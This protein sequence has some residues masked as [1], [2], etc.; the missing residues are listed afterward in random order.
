MY[1][2]IRFLSSPEHHPELIRVGQSLNLGEQE[3]FRGIRRAGDGF[4]CD[5]SSTPTWPEHRSAIMAFVTLH[6]RQ[7]AA[8]LELGGQV[9]VDVAIEPEDCDR[10]VASLRLDANLMNLLAEHGVEFELSIYR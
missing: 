1:S 6:S 4:S 3:V 2:V 10:P 5:L 7:I 9:V 8:T